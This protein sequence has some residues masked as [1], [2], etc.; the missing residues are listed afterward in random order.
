MLPEQFR[1][2]FQP[3]FLSTPPCNGD[4]LNGKSLSEAKNEFM[5]RYRPLIGDSSKIDVDTV[6]QQKIQEWKEHKGQRLLFMFVE[7]SYQDTNNINLNMQKVWEGDL[8]ELASKYSFV[9]LVGSGIPCFKE[10]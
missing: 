5:K 6:I 2:C 7:Q 8:D 3:Q 9:R 10:N 4:Y 1:A